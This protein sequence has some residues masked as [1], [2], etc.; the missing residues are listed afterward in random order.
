MFYETV[1]DLIGSLSANG[2]LDRPLT[3]ALYLSAGND[4]NQFTFTHPKFLKLRDV[5][6]VPAPNV[7]IQVDRRP[8]PPAAFHDGATRITA[9]NT[10]PLRVAGLRGELDRVRYE[11]NRFGEREVLAA[12]IT[13]D[14]EQMLSVLYRERLAPDVFIGVTDGCRYGGNRHCV[15]RL[16]MPPGRPDI[17][18]GEIPAP[19]FWITD[20]F[21]NHHALSELRPGQH[22]QSKDPNFPVRFR[23]LALLSSAWGRY[24]DSTVFGATLFAVE[25]I[26]E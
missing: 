21:E 9:T 24:R 1:S 17:P 13:A 12:R 8:Q 25:P 4:T 3:V 26:N 22:V 10:A 16:Q 2:R 23:K 15:N 5:A 20:H 11:S 6:S 7:F 19:A 18:R 14:N